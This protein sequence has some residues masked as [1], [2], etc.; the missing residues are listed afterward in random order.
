MIHV[1][2]LSELD[3][4]T[5]TD[6]A[7][8]DWNDIYSGFISEEDIESFVNEAYHPDRIE[9]MIP[10]VASGEMGFWIAEVEG[11]VAGWIQVADFGEGIEIG[12]SGLR[13]DE[14]AGALI[15]EAEGWLKAKGIKRYFSY[16][17]QDDPAYKVTL[18]THGFQHI[19]AKDD[20]GDRYLEKKL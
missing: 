13:S 14:T 15:R 6:E 18:E 16:V 9:E 2:P 12:R 10:K 20:Q 17:D 7:L 5:L 1:R 19:P 4:D 11:K 8:D 3:I